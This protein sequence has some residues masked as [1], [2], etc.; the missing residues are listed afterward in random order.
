MR[1]FT[2][3][4]CLTC[5][6]ISSFATEFIYVLGG[7]TP[8]DVRYDY[9]NEL[10]AAAI[11]HTPEFGGVEFVK[12]PYVMTR[13]RQLQELMTGEFLDVVAQPTKEDWEEKLIPVFI[14]IKK[15]IMSYRVFLINEDR[16]EEFSKITSLAEIKNLRTG[17]GS[18]W[19]TT[20]AMKAEGF[21]VVTHPE[22]VRLYPMLKAE[23]F[24]IFPRGIDEVWAEYEVNKKF[25][26]KLAIE[27]DLVLYVPLP[28]YFF[29]NPRKEK[30][31]E[32]INLGLDRMIDDGSFDKIFN[33]YY[34][35]Y[36]TQANL[37]NR[38]LFKINNI[39]V[40]AK[41]PYSV[42]KYWYKVN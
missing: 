19:S 35:D 20:R 25:N 16:Q 5:L 39:N 10:L 4:L 8:E 31:A 37:V 14:P 6:P 23:R 40:S 15:G 27:K 41:T 2:L 9:P 32:R 7:D 12:S 22:Y 3:F 36:L 42:E 29:V 11:K 24:D 18:Q 33:E 28:A 17:A 26:K 34:K 30:L 38:R 21:N 13:N 1:F